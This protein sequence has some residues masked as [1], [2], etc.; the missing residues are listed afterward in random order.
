MQKMKI[1]NSTVR[2]ACADP[3]N[4]NGGG[5]GGG[6][7]FSMEVRTSFSSRKYMTTCHFPCPPLPLCLRPYQSFKQFEF[8]LVRHFRDFLY[9]R[10]LGHMY[11]QAWA[12]NYNASL[13]I[14][15]TLN[16][17]SIDFSGC[18]KITFKTD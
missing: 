9:Q 17:L 7:C 16:K 14:R 8:T 10:V 3:N 4:F 18:E 12:Q 15:K 2:H 11:S 6:G 1:K 13:E 5:G